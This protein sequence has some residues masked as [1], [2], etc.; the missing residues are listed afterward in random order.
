M[1]SL[2]TLL[3]W[4]FPGHFTGTALKI[5]TALALLWPALIIVTIREQQEGNGSC[6]LNGVIG[7]VI[8]LPGSLLLSLLFNLLSPKRLV[9][10]PVV[11]PVD[12]DHATR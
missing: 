1:P 12:E 7:V 11:I 6:L 5:P 8:R 9:Q 10:G 2:L 4:R 3:P